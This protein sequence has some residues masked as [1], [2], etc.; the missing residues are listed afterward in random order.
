MTTRKLTTVFIVEDDAMQRS[1][2]TDHLA[3]YP[4]LKV[5]GFFSGDACVKE[6][7]VGKAEP[8]LILLDYFLEAV[9]G[10]SKDGMEILTKL[11]DFSPNSN[12]IMLTSVDNEKVIELALKKGALDYVVKNALGFDALDAVLEKHFS[13]KPAS[14]T[15]S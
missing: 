14:E 8:D 15:N 2:L 1:M 4:N 12:V 11:K 13:V 3:K 5:K 7:I 6:I 9:I 10:S